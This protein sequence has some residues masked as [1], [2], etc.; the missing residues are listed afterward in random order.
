MSSRVLHDTMEG[1]P[2]VDDIGGKGAKLPA[3][4]FMGGS[5]PPLLLGGGIGPPPEGPPGGSAPPNMPFKGGRG[6]GWWCGAGPPPPFIKGGRG[7]E[8]LEWGM[9]LRGGPPLTGIPG[10]CCWWGWCGMPPIPGGPPEATLLGI[11]WN[12]YKTQASQKGT[13]AWN[14]QGKTT[15]ESKVRFYW[16]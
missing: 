9:P 1:R 2:P 4:P 3:G 11:S 6:V 16:S 7:P 5:G 10:W 13:I 14:I 15:F 12:M 8:A